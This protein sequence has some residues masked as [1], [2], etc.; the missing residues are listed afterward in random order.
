MDYQGR[1]KSLRASGIPERAAA[2]VVSSAG[3]TCISSP[4]HRIQVRDSS[5]D[6][7][8][9]CLDAVWKRKEKPCSR[10]RNKMPTI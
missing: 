7:I 4:L 8:G 2:P 9:C 3:E 5:A 6:R 1:K 10:I